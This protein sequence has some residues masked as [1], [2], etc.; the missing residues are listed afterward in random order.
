MEARVFCRNL[1][2]IIEAQTIIDTS[3]FSGDTEL[4][5]IVNGQ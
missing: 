1:K 5:K 3:N 2:E 4:F